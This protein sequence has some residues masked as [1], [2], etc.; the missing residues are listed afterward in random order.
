MKRSFK[1]FIIAAI[2]SLTILPYL[3]G[4]LQYRNA[5]YVIQNFMNDDTDACPWGSDGDI[6]DVLRVFRFDDL[7]A[8]DIPGL[9]DYYNAGIST[10]FNY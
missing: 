4:V 9:S 2:L 8:M 6:E 3:V 10:I 1:N 5:V 7:G